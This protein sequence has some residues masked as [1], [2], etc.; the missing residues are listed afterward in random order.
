MR[1]LLPRLILLT[2]LL[3]I[4]ARAEAA[5]Y[6]VQ[7]GDT[8]S[9]IAARQ[10]VS[11]A[12]LAR[13]N[14]LANLNFIRVGQVLVIPGAGAASA[15]GTGSAGL[16]YRA[17]PGDSMYGLA[18]RFGIT[19]ATIHALN[20]RMGAYP[21]RGEWLRLCWGCSSAGAAPSYQS[22]PSQPAT[23]ASSVY[24][25]QPGDT[26]I[27]IAVRFG[28]PLSTLMAANNLIN[29]NLIVSGAR[30]AIPAASAA[31]LAPAAPSWDT[32]SLIT[33]DADLYGVPRSL[34]LAISWQESGFNQGVV[35]ATGAVGAMQV[36]PYT[37]DVISRLLGKPLNLYSVSDNI[38]AGV[39]WLSRLLA[40][41]GGNAESAIA[42]YYQG[43]KSIQRHGFFTDTVQ[44]VRNV[45]ALEARF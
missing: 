14:G 6:T 22:A 17:R 28:V 41:Y 4:P 30:L 35:S 13:A 8:L 27:G 10:Q 31:S 24:I 32:Q 36:E 20:P 44:Y 16:W 5:T 37:A 2:G 40:Y 12:E 43:I 15:T 26:L 19:F 34:A 11:L 29:S 33:S 1:R 38:Q 25:V 42:A 23:S 45:E 21:L 9:A 18:T 3:L 7:P 39:F